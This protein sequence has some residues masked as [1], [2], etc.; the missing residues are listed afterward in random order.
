MKSNHI[1]K[2]KYKNLC[3]PKCNSNKIKK[4][5]KRKTNN[6]GKIQRYRCKECDFRFVIDDGFYRMRNHPNK[7]IVGIDLYYKGFL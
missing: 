4:D 7:I 6:R 1:K 3:C 5:G 2:G